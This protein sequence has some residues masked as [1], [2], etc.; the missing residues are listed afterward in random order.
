[1]TS[2]VEV[3]SIRRGMI[4]TAI[5]HYELL[6]KSYEINSKIKERSSSAGSSS[7]KLLQTLQNTQKVVEVLSQTGILWKKES[8]LCRHAAAHHSILLVVAEAPALVE[9]AV[10]QE[11]YTEVLDVIR[12]IERLT[13]Y[14]S[15]GESNG[16]NAALNGN[17]LP[18]TNERGANHNE[19]KISGVSNREDGGRVALLEALRLRTM[20]A[21]EHSLTNTVLPRL[22]RL[23]LSVESV[24]RIVQFF[25]LL[26]PN[27]PSCFFEELFL[28]CRHSY[29]QWLMDE[30]RRDY[31]EPL[32]RAKRYLQIYRGPISEVVL[33]YRACFV[34]AMTSSYFSSIGVPEDAKGE[35]LNKIP[36]LREQPPHQET[37]I[38]LL[39]QWCRSRGEELQDALRD[40]LQQI[41]NSYELWQIWEESHAACLSAA[42]TQFSLWPMVSALIVNRIAM[43]FSHHTTQA[44]I[45]YLESMKTFSWKPSSSSNSSSF[46]SKGGS[47]HL[48]S[49]WNQSPLSV[50]A[51]NLHNPH[52]QGSTSFSSHSLSGSH[53]SVGV[54]TG[55]IMDLVPPAALTDF[56]P[57]AFALNEFINAAN[58]IHRLILPG[59]SFYCIR[60]VIDLLRYV[61]ADLARDAEVMMGAGEE[62]KK[63]FIAVLNAFEQ[64]FFPHVCQCILRL[65]GEQAAHQVERAVL[66]LLN[67]LYAI[68]EAELTAFEDGLP[69]TASQPIARDAFPSVQ[70]ST[71]NG[72]VGTRP[73]S[74]PV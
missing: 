42:K 41:S 1:M 48:F 62:S 11:M 70:Q 19:V 56:P 9:E 10:H 51:K 16:D 21:L 59:L 39:S 69:L 36:H 15:K 43:L 54:G 38:C 52:G 7:E 37:E 64:L 60:D 28:A 22:C 27:A 2:D 58:I 29:I 23:P 53:S 20:S 40:E 63:R 14:V 73:S 24:F 35:T 47:A 45:L 71:P 3:N 57:L 66:P 50:V 55:G 34:S 5:E 49:L 74:L 25:R 30:V 4:D 31:P 26:S 68:R 65:F 61:G 44:K 67:P 32:Q 33:Q 8:Q 13:T 12:Y 72:D 17:S 46:T 18:G 6:T